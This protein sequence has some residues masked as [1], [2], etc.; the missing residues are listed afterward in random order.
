MYAVDV[1]MRFV[2]IASQLA[3]V[4]PVVSGTADRSTRT[5]LLNRLKLL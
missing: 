3:A 2:Q 4:P 1:V 5:A